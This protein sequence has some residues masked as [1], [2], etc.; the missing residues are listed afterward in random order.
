MECESSGLVAGNAVDEAMTNGSDALAEA[1]TL[2]AG[3][4]T[5]R[6]PRE[7]C[8]IGPFCFL[9]RLLYCSGVRKKVENGLR[10]RA[11]AHFQ[12][13]LQ[14]SLAIAT[15]V[16]VTFCNTVE[17][18]FKTYS[19]CDCIRLEGSKLGRPGWSWSRC[20][21]SSL[22]SGLMEEKHAQHIFQNMSRRCP[23]CPKKLRYR[24]KRI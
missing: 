24:R 23:N 6:S 3:F 19:S 16:S 13:F 10:T 2:N 21:W 15:R 5:P 8:C 9:F 7:D 12:L 11:G 17:R 14:K 4:Q 22:V 20:Q 1:S 18:R